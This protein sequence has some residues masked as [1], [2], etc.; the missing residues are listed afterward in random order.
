MEPEKI[1]P[2]A[3][4]NLLLPLVVTTKTDLLRLVQELKSLQNFLH[5]AAI[6]KT[7]VDKLPAISNMLIKT[8]EVNKLNLADRNDCDYLVSSLDNIKNQ[9][10][11]VAV[12]F[13][14]DP[15]PRFL[16]RIVE[17]FRQEAHPYTLLQ[18]GLQ[19]TIAGGCIVRTRS[20]YFDL[21]LRQYL[22]RQQDQLIE[23]I[24]G[25]PS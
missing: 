8:A 3:S 19:P 4:K 11:V 25:E 5:Q 6:R 2:P 9:A 14:A 1:S 18:V 22:N 21:S 23:K 12:S 15:Q 7:A 10:P 17:W 20:K 24:R 13:A 16:G